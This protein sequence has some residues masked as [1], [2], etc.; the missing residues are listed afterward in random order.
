MP[1]CRQT[2]SI[3]MMEYW[4]IIGKPLTRI[5]EILNQVQNDK[6]QLVLKEWNKNISFT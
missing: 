3:G 1:A 2:G 6:I 5:K 4:V